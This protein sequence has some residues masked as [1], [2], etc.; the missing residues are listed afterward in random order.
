MDSGGHAYDLYRRFLLSIIIS[1]LEC[2]PNIF[3][4]FANKNIDG[5][6]ALTTLYKYTV[7]NYA[8]PNWIVCLIV[9]PSSRAV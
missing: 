6:D 1:K 2:V 9:S 7:S 4:S 3:N 5:T 8:L